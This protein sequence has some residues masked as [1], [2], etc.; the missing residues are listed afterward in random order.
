MHGKEK[1]I[2]ERIALEAWGD[3]CGPMDVATMLQLTPGLEAYPLTWAA[4]SGQLKKRDIPGPDLV[5]STR[6]VLGMMLLASRAVEIPR[7]HLE[8]GLVRD[9]VD[10]QGQSF[11]WTR[12]LGDML[13]VQVQKIKPAHAFVSTHYRGYWFYID[14]ADLSSKSTFALIQLVTGLELAGGVVP[15]PVV[16]VTTGG[17]EAAPCNN[18][19]PAAKAGAAAGAKPRHVNPKPARLPSF[20]QAPLL[21]PPGERGL[22]RSHRIPDPLLVESLWLHQPRVPFAKDEQLAHLLVGSLA[23]ARS[24]RVGLALEAGRQVDRRT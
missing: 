16:S 9:P 1:H 17:G 2:V 11:D 19:S 15:G 4:E 7:K 14:D 20:S 13:H 12:V 23:D 8:E 3:P 21:P 22:C 6:S 5:I 18:A 24:P 10:A